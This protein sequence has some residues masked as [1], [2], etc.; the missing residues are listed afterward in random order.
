MYGW[1]QTSYKYIININF[2]KLVVHKKIVSHK[3]KIVLDNA[4]GIVNFEFHNSESSYGKKV[5]DQYFGNVS[6]S[7]TRMQNKK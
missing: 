7:T 1:F 6:T 4:G 3:Q 5:Y 2:F